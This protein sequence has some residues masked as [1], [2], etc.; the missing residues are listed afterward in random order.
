MNYRKEE[1]QRRPRKGVHDGTAWQIYDEQ[2]KRL[3]EARGNLPR[4]LD[5]R[6]YE[7]TDLACTYRDLDGNLLFSYPLMAED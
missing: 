5:G 2:G 7:I 6:V 1:L 3:G 4:L